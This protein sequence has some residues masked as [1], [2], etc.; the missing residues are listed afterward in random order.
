MPRHVVILHPLIH[1]RVMPTCLGQVYSEATID[2][3]ASAK[4]AVAHYGRW[5]AC[6]A[7]RNGR[8]LVLT[9]DSKFNRGGEQD[10]P[11]KL[12][13][14]FC[15]AALGKATV[16]IW[17]LVK[18]LDPVYYDECVEIL[19]GRDSE[20]RVN[21]DPRDLFSLF[22]VGVHGYTQRHRDRNDIAG[23]FTVLCTLGHYVGKSIQ[24][25]M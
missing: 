16:M 10:N 4:M 2:T 22:A 14:R 25:H 18:P 13:A 9:K 6:S 20:Y 15:R 5:S 19:D 17:V 3:L 24:F 11:Q 23:G 21:T 1:T 8:Q 12:F 7:D